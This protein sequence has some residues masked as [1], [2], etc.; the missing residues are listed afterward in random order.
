MCRSLIDGLKTQE[1]LMDF[2]EPVSMRAVI[3]TPL[4]RQKAKGWWATDI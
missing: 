4:M 1:L 3:R 2:M